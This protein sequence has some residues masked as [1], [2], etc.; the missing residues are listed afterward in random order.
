MMQFNAPI[1][2]PISQIVVVQSNT[3]SPSQINLNSIETNVKG[4]CACTE[5]A[6]TKKYRSLLH[7][8]VTSGTTTPQ[9]FQIPGFIRKVGKGIVIIEMQSRETCIQSTCAST[10]VTPGSPE[11]VS[12]NQ[13]QEIYI[14]IVLKVKKQ[15]KYYSKS[16]LLRLKMNNIQIATKDDLEAM[17]QDLDEIKQILKQQ[18]EY[19]EN[20]LKGYDNDSRNEP[21]HLK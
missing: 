16:F 4:E 3:L 6:A 21:P 8:F 18:N 17:K 14:R 2:I 7:E 19:I 15:K 5:E 1:C 11:S 9:K 13:I 12:T 10:F 20:T